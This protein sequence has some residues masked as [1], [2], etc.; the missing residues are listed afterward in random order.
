MMM[1][2]ATKSDESR[3]GVPN[4]TPELLFVGMT[5]GVGLALVGGLCLLPVRVPLGFR[6]AVALALFVFALAYLSTT[7]P[8]LTVPT[9]AAA[10]VAAAVLVCAWLGTRR[11][12][13]S[14]RKAVAVVRLPAVRWGAMCALGLALIVLSSWKYEAD[15]QSE[16]S[17]H[18]DL[19]EI[20]SGIPYPPIVEVL[21]S[22]IVTDLGT[23]VPVHS[24]TTVRDPER[25]EGFEQQLLRVPSLRER[26]IRLEPPDDTCNCHGWV[27]AAGGLWIDGEAV[28]LILRENGYRVV[29]KPAPGDLVVYRRSNRP[30]HSAVVRYVSEG[31]P[32]LAESKWAWMGVYVHRV[33]DTVYGTEWTYHRSSRAGHTL[34]GVESSGE[35]TTALP[36]D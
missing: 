19:F 7:L 16:I 22:G 1:W 5:C 2:Q 36:N 23:P 9:V 21:A 15:A 4:L 18:S 17:E 34:R 24:A 29:S 14:V 32:A 6:L 35:D 31:M 20:A 8:D 10:L 25:L 12:V 27:F 28:E 3:E 30:V 26:V 33:D 13:R 11:W